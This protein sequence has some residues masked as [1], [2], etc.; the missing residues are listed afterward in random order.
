MVHPGRSE[1][2]G[3]AEPAGDGPVFYA[4]AADVPPPWPGVWWRVQ[5]GWYREVAPQPAAPTPEPPRPTPTA[6]ET[7]EPRTDEEERNIRYAP[8]PPRKR[9]PESRRARDRA[10]SRAYRRDGRARRRIPTPESRA[11]VNARMRVYLAAWRL[12][13]GRAVGANRVHLKWAAVGDEPV[14]HLT[15]A[16]G[17]ATRRPPA[18]SHAICEPHRRVRRWRGTFPAGVAPVEP[19]R[20]RRCVQERARWERLLEITAAEERKSPPPE[21]PARQTIAWPPPTVDP[22]RGDVDPRRCR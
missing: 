17:W 18:G 4:N 3:Y 21:R 22:R 19:L 16:R 10:F 1:W 20:C 2:A 14:Y 13:T 8:G 12:R 15:P 5:G 9:T 7:T 11:K 6:A